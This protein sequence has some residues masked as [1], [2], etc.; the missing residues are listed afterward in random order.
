[1]PNIFRGF[2][3]RPPT[4]ISES[5]A[6]GIIGEVVMPFLQAFIPGLWCTL[7][8]FITAVALWAGD[9]AIRWFITFICAVAFIVYLILFDARDWKTLAQV[10][11]GI[12]AIGIASY[13]FGHGINWLIEWQQPNRT[14]VLVLWCV[15]A[16]MWLG[17]LFMLMCFALELFLRSPAM[18]EHGFRELFTWL[19]QTF[20][21]RP[22]AARPLPQEAHRVEV[23]TR[24][25]NGSIERIDNIELPVSKEIMRQVAALVLDGSNFSEPVMVRNGGPLKAPQFT[26]LREFLLQRGF[27]QWK[28]QENNLLGVQ[29]T[30]GGMALVRSYLPPPPETE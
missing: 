10:V 18:E 6:T 23:V 4:Q 28:D 13:S 12:L 16:G 8:L 7:A 25:T 24:D 5:K 15:T 17:F 26:A 20:L 11:A 21:T 2:G 3:V 14:T 29:W 19:F 22:R 27:V 9:P 1:M 30:P